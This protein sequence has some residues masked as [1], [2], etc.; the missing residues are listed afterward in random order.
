MIKQYGQMVHFIKKV[1]RDEE[2]KARC[3]LILHLYNVL[4]CGTGFGLFDLGCF[5]VFLQVKVL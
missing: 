4:H 1:Q 5:G 2:M 3:C